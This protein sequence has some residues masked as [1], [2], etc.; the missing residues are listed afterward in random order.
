MTKVYFSPGTDCLN[1]IIDNL[2]KARRRAKI[3][4]FTISDNRI[5]DAIKEMQLNGVNIKIISDNDKRYDKGN[6]IDYIASL[7]ID[8]K[9]DTTSAHMHHKFAVIDD[10][11][12]ITGSYN[13]TR[14]AETKKSRKHPDN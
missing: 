4:V 3:C 5:V 11:I 12:T 13:W 8:V 1:A 2:K 6:D 14:S 7:G 9:I 10:T